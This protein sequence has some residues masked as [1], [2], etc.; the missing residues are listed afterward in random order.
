[1][2]AT[3]ANAPIQPTSV[4]IQVLR[5]YF[6][7]ACRYWPDDRRATINIRP[8]DAIGSPMVADLYVCEGH[9]ENLIARARGGILECRSG[10]LTDRTQPFLKG[11]ST[12][13]GRYRERHDD[14]PVTSRR[15]L[16]EAEALRRIAVWTA[17]ISTN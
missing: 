9:A 16:K 14:L 12:G 15:M 6:E 7:A 3:F 8:V 2:G 13:V 1:V 4:E 5:I 10:R 17:L 11:R